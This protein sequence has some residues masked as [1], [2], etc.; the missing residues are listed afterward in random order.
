MK[1]LANDGLDKNAIAFFEGRGISVDTVHRSA[2][3]LETG[4]IDF[5]VIIIRSKTKVTA[6]ILESF[7]KAGMSL[8]IRAGVGLDNIDLEKANEL[9]IAVRNTPNSSTRSV[10]EIVIGQMFALARFIPASNL[11]IRRG[12][13][14]KKEYEGVTLKGKTLGV[15][16]FGRIGQEVAR[17]ARLLSMD[18]IY[19]DIQCDD[20][21]ICKKLDLD[22]L[23]KLSDFITIHIPFMKD[24][25]LGKK[26]FDLMKPG[27]FI[28][29]YARG[30][31]IDL[32]ALVEAIHDGKVGGAALD[33]FP[34]EP[35][36]PKA[37]MDL[38]QV[39]LTP[40]IGAATKEAQEAIGEEII[41]I[42]SS[43]FLD[44]E[45]FH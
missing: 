21:G 38:D 23:L 32:D 12:E 17:I 33:V 3:E 18:V 29:N 45:E 9:G 43:T 25:V 16:G 42:V 34:D 37:L 7:K 13:W 22:E 15:I 6:E 30:N 20:E 31:A 1:I 40:H 39:S 26:E 5:D 24:P 27:A 10:A 35:N 36:V 11:S 41:Q 4:N 28:L 14:N 2:E 19:F 8:V 44:L